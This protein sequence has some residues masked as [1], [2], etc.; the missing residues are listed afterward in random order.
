MFTTITAT[1]AER[2]AGALDAERAAAAAAALWRDGTMVLAGTV[3]LDHIDAVRERME[4]DV[5]ELVRRGKTNGPAGH[6]SHNPPVAAPHVFADVIANPIA[7]QVARLAVGAP[8]QLTLLTGNTILPCT[9][10]QTLHRD[11]GNLW[12]DVD[13]T[14]PPPNISVHVP[15]MDIDEENGSTEVWPGTHR[16]AHEGPVPTEQSELDARAAIAPP[17]QVTAPA[18]SIILRDARAWHRGMP[19]R[20]DRTRLM[21]G[22]IY[23]ARWARGGRL[24]FHRSAEPELRDAPLEIDPVWVDDDFDHLSGLR[25]AGA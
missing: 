5:D 23:A 16:L 9:E 7:V 12:R 18:G 22:M 6:Y 11:Q 20:T 21:I 3:D 1:E 10:A 2:A 4:A 24:P 25:P 17:A 13:E 8:L 14:H 19:N 15:L